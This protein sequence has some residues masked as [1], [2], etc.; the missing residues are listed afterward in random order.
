MRVAIGKY[1]SCFSVL[2]MHHHADEPLGESF[3]R[4]VRLI[5]AFCLNASFVSIFSTFSNVTPH[6]HTGNISILTCVIIILDTII[7]LF[8]FHMLCSYLPVLFSYYDLSLACVV[9][10]ITKKNQKKQQHK[11]N[12]TAEDCPFFIDVIYDP[13][14][15]F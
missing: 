15:F 13:H 11:K 9:I 3:E 7:H 4:S 10:F 12:Q 8:Y 6:A 1:N 2:L 5:T 14:V